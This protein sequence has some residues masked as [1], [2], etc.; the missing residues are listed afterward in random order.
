MPVAPRNAFV[1]IL[2]AALS[3]AACEKAEDTKDI[4]VASAPAST[5]PP[6]EQEIASLNATVTLP[7]SWK[8]GYKIVDRADT[9]FGGY[10][11]IEFLYAADTAR[12][13]PPRLLL[14][15]R[16]FRKPAWEKI[17]ATQQGVSRV[18]AT[19]GD[20]IITFSHVTANPYPANTP[21]ALRVDAMMIALTGETTPFRLSFKPPVS[22]KQ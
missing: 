1:M 5:L 13:V 20:D 3:M 19:H 22:A 18:L 4:G 9:T 12:Q 15:I 8:Y 6:F 17:R 7:G 11:A 14:V 10:R 21:S 2:L 16:V